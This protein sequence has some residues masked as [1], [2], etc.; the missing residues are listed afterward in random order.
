MSNL[1]LE[2]IGSLG[3]K[4]N[5]IFKTTEKNNKTIKKNQIYQSK[6]IFN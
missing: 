2:L 6:S 3:V 1:K 5:E 4:S